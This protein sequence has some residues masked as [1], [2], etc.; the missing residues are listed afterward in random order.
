MADWYQFNEGGNG[1]DVTQ[2]LLG[3]I[4]RIDVN[5]GDPYGIPYGIPQDNPFVGREGLD[6]I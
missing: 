3:S 4:L 1:Q 5:T 2:N 6:E